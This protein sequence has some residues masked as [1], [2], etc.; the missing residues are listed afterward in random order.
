[1]LQETT[2][3]EHDR[4]PKYPLGRA[5]DWLDGGSIL[6]NFVSEADF[7]SRTKTSGEKEPVFQSVM[8]AYPLPIVSSCR[9]LSCA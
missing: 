6:L 7:R 9:G 3:V 4:G 8:L 5:P 1:M 2:C